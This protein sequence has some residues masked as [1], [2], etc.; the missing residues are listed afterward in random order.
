MNIDASPWTRVIGDPGSN[1][2]SSSRL[3]QPLPRRRALGA[4]DALEDRPAERAPHPGDGVL[5][6]QGHVSSLPVSPRQRTPT[7]AWQPPRSAVSSHSR[8]IA[9]HAAP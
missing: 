5:E 6:R 1:Q 3:A 8:P 7:L 4:G 9:T 2:R